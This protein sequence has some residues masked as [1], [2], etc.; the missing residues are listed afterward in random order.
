MYSLLK[1][2]S[3]YLNLDV[4]SEL[5]WICWLRERSS[6]VYVVRSS[7]ILFCSSRRSRNCL[8]I[9]ARSYHKLASSLSLRLG[10]LLD[11]CLSSSC[12]QE[13]IAYR[14]LYFLFN[15]SESSSSLPPLIA[16]SKSWSVFCPAFFSFA[17]HSFLNASNS[18]FNC[19]VFLLDSSI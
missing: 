3:S 19:S 17:S 6:L 15:S 16:W 12:F 8:L 13:S 11:N 14:S 4:S 7:K 5:L 2:S 1:N 10:S 18:A 9:E